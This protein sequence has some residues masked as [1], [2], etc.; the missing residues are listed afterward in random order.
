MLMIGSASARRALHHVGVAPP[1]ASAGRCAVG[2]QVEPQELIAV[3]GMGSPSTD[4][5]M[6]TISATFDETR[7]REL[8]IFE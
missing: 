6:I 7:K 2:Q 3:S 8:A 4:T 5:K 1:I